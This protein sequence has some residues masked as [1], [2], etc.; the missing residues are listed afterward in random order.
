M[1]F[2]RTVTVCFVLLVPGAANFATAAERA[3]PESADA[4]S[5]P[6]LEVKD[7]A[8]CNFGISVQALGNPQTRQIT[9]LF[10]TDVWEKS[11]AEKLGLKPGDEILAIN[12]IKV[13]DMKGGMQRGSDLFELLVNR[14]K[15]ARIR[16]E[17]EV[18]V[19]KRF[20][21]TAG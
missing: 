16:L 4:V 13:S 5:L 10:I 11:E 9:R 12:G 20:T 18:R 19:T 7:N 8:Y 2:L 6:P 1:N 14:G 17:V 3:A 21:L 15:G